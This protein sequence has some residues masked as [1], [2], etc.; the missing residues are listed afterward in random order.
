MG[1]QKLSSCISCKSTI[2]EPFQV[3]IAKTNK[4]ELWNQFVI[5]RPNILFRGQK[6]SIHSQ[7]TQNRGQNL[8]I[9]T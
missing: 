6:P 5:Q 4:S 1:K 2:L 7:G 9:L 3:K 8:K